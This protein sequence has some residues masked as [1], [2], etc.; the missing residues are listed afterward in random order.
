MAKVALKAMGGMV[1]A[2]ACAVVGVGA[3]VAQSP[4]S[5]PDEYSRLVQASNGLYASEGFDGVAGS[6]P[7]PAWWRMETGGGGW[8]NNEL[9]RY[10]A[11]ARNVALD[12]HGN[13]AISAVRD[14]RGYTS[15]R[16]SS[17]GSFWF[18]NGLF[19][20][21]AR[22]PMNPGLLP[23]IW[24]L[25]SDVDR[26]GYPEAGEIDVFERSGQDTNLGVLGPWIDVKKKTPWKAQFDYPG[27]S[28]TDEFHV[29]WINKTPGRISFG[30]DGLV[31]KT[32]TPADVPKGGVW[33]QDAPFSPVLS[34]A[35]GGDW[36]GMP[37][38]ASTP[39]TML[40]DWVRVYL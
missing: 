6:P 21:R 32:L 40:V 36:A 28:L 15:G 14:G 37:V 24:L 10:T 1:I 13:L 34:L 11:N 12:G 33:V 17:L 5:K 22:L 20:V 30:V 23:A 26:I 39:A 29:Y 8:G 38:A 19:A 25:G 4:A 31:I 18:S 16:I 2:F 27:A 7:T 3:W 35:V 9:Q